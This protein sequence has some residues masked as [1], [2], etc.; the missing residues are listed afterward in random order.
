MALVTQ[1]SK[2]A[3]QLLYARH[4]LQSWQT[5]VPDHAA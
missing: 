1:E 2:A 3:V 4:L 5:N